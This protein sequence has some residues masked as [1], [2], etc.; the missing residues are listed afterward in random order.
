[1]HAQKEEAERRSRN[2][3]SRVGKCQ[4]PGIFSIPCTIGN[5]TFA[6]AM[7]DLSALINV[8]PSS[9]YKS[10]Y[11]GDLEPMGMI[12]H[13]ANRSVVQPLGILE[14]VLVQVD[15]LIFPVDFYVLDME[16]DTSRKG[17]TLILGRPV[18]M[19]ARTK[20]DVHART[21]SME[22][23]DNLVQFNIFEVMKHP[24]EDHSLFSID[25]IDELVE[26]HM[27]LG[28]SRAKISHFVE[29]PD[30]DS[31]NRFQKLMKAEFD[32][33]NQEEAEIDSNNLEEAETD[34]NN[35]EEV[36][37]DSIS[38]SEAKCDSGNLECKQTK[39]K[40]G[41]RQLIP[42]L[43]RVS[44][45]IPR[46]ANKF[47]PPHSPPTKL[48]PLLDHL[49]YAYLDDHQHF[50]II[51]ANNLHREQEEKFL[52]VLRK[53]KKVIGWTLSDLPGINPSIYMHKILLEE[54][55]QPIR[56]Q[57]RRL[58]LTIL[59]IVKKEVTRLLVAGIIYPISDSQWVSLKQVV[60][61]K[62]GMAVMKNWHD[63][64]V[65]TRILNSWRVYSRVQSV[66]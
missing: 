8:M 51:I 31:G 39:A 38:Q 29:I 7:L 65:P 33:N 24:T 30:F 41:S 11:F 20:S 46:S 21:L 45:L 18:L 6:D 58:N 36:D 15:E 52:N 27:Q 59:D 13:L 60:P 43:D 19:T 2:G 57:Q 23:D 17:S 3:K 62:S 35:L 22:F 42:H 9:I 25:I 26:E 55:A 28:I 34:S 4:D 56:K 53:H 1:M 50:P 14:D 40:Y 49:K 48:K 16:D 5:C 47:S 66:C 64:M 37:T 12:I 10:L 61:K 44:Q 54:E 32:S 63:E